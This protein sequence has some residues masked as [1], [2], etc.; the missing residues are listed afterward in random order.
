MILGTSSVIGNVFL[1]YSVTKELD[2]F[3]VIVQFLCE[4]MFFPPWNTEMFDN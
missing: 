4:E 3:F 2:L 1:Q